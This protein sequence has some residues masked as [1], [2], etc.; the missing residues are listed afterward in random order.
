M[1]RV[2]ITGVKKL[3]DLIRERRYFVSIGANET[4]VPRSSNDYIISVDVTLIPKAIED[5]DVRSFHLKLSL[6][7]VYGMVVCNNAFFFHPKEVNN[8][9][10]SDV[11]DSTLRTFLVSP[12]DVLFFSHDSASYMAPAAKRLRCVHIWLFGTTK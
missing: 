11:I 4:D 1:S 6:P 3:G 12:E 2:G 9:T 8:V 10:L 5:S 7:E